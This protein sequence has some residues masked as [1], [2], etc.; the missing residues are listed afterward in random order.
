MGGAG[1]PD[2]SPDA[3]GKSDASPA[4]ARGN[5]SGGVQGSG[6]T[7]GTGG[8][9]GTGGSSAACVPAASGGPGGMNDGKP[10]V[11][12]HGSSQSPK[13]TAAGTVYSSATGGK[14]VSG[15]TVTITGNNG[16]KITMVTGSSGNF[17]TGSAITFPATVQISKCPDIAT[18]PVT[19]SS[20]DCNSC[21]G[22]SSA[23]LHLP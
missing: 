12:C 6:G 3:G 10:C 1:A 22:S 23:V 19:L 20:G 17:Y 18:M 2:A 13:M 4:D 8:A 11:S 7:Q 14:G 5:S 15:A 21:H 9:T 16:T